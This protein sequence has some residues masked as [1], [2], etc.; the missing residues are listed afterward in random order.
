MGTRES[1]IQ[2]IWVDL[3]GLAFS[4][5]VPRVVLYSYCFY[6]ILFKSWK[7]LDSHKREPTT[8]KQD[9]EPSFLKSVL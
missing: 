7:S 2:N 9:E 5:W 8:C 1:F 4:E 6:T 3:R